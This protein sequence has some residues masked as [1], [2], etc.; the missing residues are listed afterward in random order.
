[1]TNSMI[2]KGDFIEMDIAEGKV[3]VNGVNKTR[4]LDLTCSFNRFMVRTGD[5][6]KC[7]NGTPLI[8]YR[9]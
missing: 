1:M 5:L 2:K 6:G 3:F 7:D 8:R 4:S 9:G